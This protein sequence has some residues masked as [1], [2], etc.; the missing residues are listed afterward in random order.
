MRK[1]WT[2][3]FKIYVSDIVI[4]VASA[5]IGSLIAGYFSFGYWAGFGIIMVLIA[6]L[7]VIES[8]FIKQ[9]Y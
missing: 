9:D 8:L 2:K 1:W 4:W 6:L 7:T 3:S 5:I